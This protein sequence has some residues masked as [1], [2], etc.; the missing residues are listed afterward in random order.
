MWG[1]LRLWGYAY[2]RRV[3]AGF[4]VRDLY[5][6]ARFK[7]VN[8]VNWPVKGERQGQEVRSGLNHRSIVLPPP[9]RRAISG[10]ISLVHL[11][12]RSHIW[13]RMGQWHQFAR[14]SPHRVMEWISN[15]PQPILFFAS[16]RLPLMKACYLLDSLYESLDSDI[17][18]LMNHSRR[19]SPP[20]QQIMD[21]IYHSWLAYCLLAIN[22]PFYGTIL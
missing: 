3:F 6:R 5:N 22:S 10:A 11:T 13:D 17:A 15:S 16:T 20:V 18:L 14:F 19:P 9:R 1:N 8:K 2:R 12:E 7:P 21:C 4:Q